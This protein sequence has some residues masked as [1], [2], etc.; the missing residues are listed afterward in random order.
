MAT[1]LDKI[2]S[3]HR[4]WAKS[5]TRRTGEL[6]KIAL[7]SEPCLGFREALI[8]PGVSIIAEI[9]RRSPSKG[10]LN[11]ALDPVAL[12]KSYEMHGASCISILTDEKYFSGSLADL[13]NVRSAVRIPLLRKDFTISAN[14]VLDA[15]IHG[16]DAVLLIVS[17]LSGHELAELYGIS[18]EVG[19]DVL[20]EVHDEP[21]FVQAQDIGADLIGVNQRDLTTFEVDPDKALTLSTLFDAS[22]VRVCE[23]GI[24]TTDQ[25]RSL[26]RMGYDAALIGE[27]LVRSSDP[28]VS[29]AELIQAGMGDM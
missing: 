3:D 24:S 14:D 21:E 12:A 10:D 17:A 28:G 20:V 26:A 7:D 16:A 18:K 1:Y 27:T 19:L 5:D 11:P 4:A 13:S 22:T 29:L 9:K 2:I 25:M 15:K 23:S 6:L 8:G